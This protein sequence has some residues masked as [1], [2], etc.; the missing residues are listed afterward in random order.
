MNENLHDASKS[1]KFEELSNSHRYNAMEDE[2]KNQNEN[3]EENQSNK[4]KANLPGLQDLQD[5][6]NEDMDMMND[7]QINTL[8]EPVTVTIVIKIAKIYLDLFFFKILIPCILDILLN[9]RIGNSN[10]LETNYVMS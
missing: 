5:E 10:K 9:F 3:N 8:G 1:E 6:L 4:N 7:L 2:N